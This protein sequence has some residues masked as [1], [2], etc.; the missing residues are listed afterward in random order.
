MDYIRIIPC[1]AVLTF[2]FVV[3]SVRFQEPCMLHDDTKG[4]I[5]TEHQIERIQVQHIGL[6]SYI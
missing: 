1:V 6:V 4:I 3:T 5:L 2:V